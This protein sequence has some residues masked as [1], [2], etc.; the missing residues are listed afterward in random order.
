MPVSVGEPLA[1]PAPRGDCPFDPAP[2][3]TAVRD[4]PGMTQVRLWDSSLAWLVT[5]DADVR[6][7][8]ADPRFSADGNR[9]GFVSFAPG[10]VSADATFIR[11]DDPEHA[12]LRRMPARYFSVRQVEA[13]RPEIQILADELVDAMLTTATADLVEAFAFPLPSLVISRLLGVP[14]DDHAFFEGATRRIMSTGG[15][16]EESAAALAEF[17]SYMSDLAD[18][19]AAGPDDNILAHLVQTH[20]ASGELTRPDTIRMALQLLVAGHETVANMISGSVAALLTHRDQWDL[21]LADDT[22]LRPAVDE[23]L[24]YLS[25][26]QSGISRIAVEDVRV[27]DHLVRAGENVIIHLPTANHD[28]SVHLDP[29]RLD[30]NRRPQRHL[31]Y[32]H[33]V[34]QCQ[35]KA[36]GSLEIEIALGTLLRRVPALDLAVPLADVPF[37]SEMFIYGVHS[38]PVTW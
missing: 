27:G 29:G 36:L 13:M 20:E 6:A 30:I 9:D 17:M 31:A 12:R 23:L 11:M 8:L 22:L 24:R 25:V 15:T 34:H 33:G 16:R 35:G 1:Y 26:I 38:L 4:G 19:R 3:Y 7:V 28:P 2:L 10:V 37:R 14:Y 5:R 18:A 21:L 32:G